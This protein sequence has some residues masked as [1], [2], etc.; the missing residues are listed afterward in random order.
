VNDRPDR[1]ARFHFAGAFALCWGALIAYSLLRVPVPGVNEPHYLGMARAEWDPGWCQ[2]DFF[3]SSARPHR[4]FY[5]LVGWL[6][7]VVSLEQAAVVGRFASLALLAWGW[8]RLGRATGLNASG[9]VQ[10]GAAFLVLQTIGSWSGEWLIGGVESKVFAYGLLFA[11]WGALIERRT[12][13][14]ATWLGLATTM[15][16]VVG[17]WG[18]MATLSALAWRWWREAGQS[19]ERQAP[20]PKLPLR[21]APSLWWFITA[22][23]GIGWALPALRSADSQTSRTADFIQVSYRL[24]HHLDPWTFSWQSHAFFA[25]LIAA[26]MWSRCIRREDRR[27]DLLDVVTAFAVLFGLMATL[28]T[29]GSRPW[30][31]PPSAVEALQ[32]KLLKFYPFRLADTMSTLMGAAAVVGVLGRVPS[33][34]FRNALTVA[35]LAAAIVLPGPDQTPGMLAGGD[36]ED[37]IATLRWVRANTPRDSLLLAVNEDFGVKWWS[38]RA[39]YVNFKDCPQDARGVVEWNTRLQRFS[40]WTEISLKDGKVSSGDLAALR[41]ATGVTHLIAS[42]FGPIEAEPVYRRG[43]FRVIATEER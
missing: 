41:S 29:A 8:A 31:Y 39:E 1:G 34:P 4:A 33:V 26:W 43:R 35:M 23:P 14:A 7:R 17:M 15:H 38:E 36:R 22:A 6:T 20:L 11:G 2:G 18:T 27:F 24:A 12:S 25:G 9:T 21:L 40:A 42:R 19:A 5:M 28:L 10:W 16:P 37:W 13:A 3:L 32:L 30:G